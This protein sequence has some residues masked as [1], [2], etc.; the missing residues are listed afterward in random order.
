MTD[1]DDIFTRNALI[2]SERWPA[3]WDRLNNASWELTASISDVGP[4]PTLVIDGIHLS[5]CY[6][7]VAEAELQ[8]SVVP[9]NAETVWLYGIGV[10]ELP[11]VLLRSDSLKQLNIVL[12][13]TVEL[14]FS[15][16]CFDH[17]QWLSD[18]RV[19]L[20][21]A[22]T[23]QK[24]NH[25]YAVVPVSV[26][27]A[28]EEAT[29]LCNK[30]ELELNTEFINTAFRTNPAHLANLEQNKSFVERDHDVAELFHTA[31]GVTVHIAAA[32]PTLKDHF[33]SLKRRESGILIA[34]DAALRPLLQNN[35]IPDF[36][37]TI[38]GKREPVIDFFQV[39]KTKLA[40]IKMV[41]FPI[42]HPDVVRACDECTRYVAYSSSPIFEDLS[43]QYKRGVL[44]SSGS[45]IHPAIDLG[46]QMGARTIKLYGA[47]FSYTD[48]STHVEGAANAMQTSAVTSN[49]WVDNG[50]AQKVPTSSNF[51]GY[52]IDVERYV[53]QH[54]Q[55]N[56]I[57]MG[58]KGAVI[59]GTR[60]YDEAV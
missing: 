17:S 3:V 18:Q 22:N 56:F 36:V 2:L 50:F 21:L 26:R 11:R 28:D 35:I 20:I 4:E 1:Q 8:A 25:P 38:D 19:Q 7:K 44:Y 49:C 52:L 53:A 58:R 29:K 15:I 55:V 45:V 37:V 41:Y 46:V 48:K 13:S 16:Q 59:E 14:G 30:L 57:N 33:V 31:D 5:S 42:V 34:V 43:Q 60:Y 9:K 54:P 10:G 23:Q 6:D 27:L 39:D 47:D 24:L 12:L 40:S 51:L 32:G